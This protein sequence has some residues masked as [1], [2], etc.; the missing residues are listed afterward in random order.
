MN[1]LC[2]I[3]AREYL[4]TVR[5]RAFLLAVVLMPVLIAGSALLPALAERHADADVRRFS[6]VDRTGGE[7]HLG[8]FTA[9]TEREEELR[10][11]TSS[12]ARFEVVP[13]PAEALLRAPEELRA[14]LAE[15]LDSGELFAFVEIEGA[16][17]DPAAGASP[18]YFTR[19]PT[20]TKLHAWLHEEVEGTVHRLRIRRA[21]LDV[22]RVATALRPVPLAFGSLAED[23]SSSQPGADSAEPLRDALSPLI[24]AFLLF[25]V[26][27]SAAGPLMQGVLE[28][29]MQRIAEILVSSVP[30]FQLMLAKL[31]AAAAVSYTLLVLY[32]GAGLFV[33]F[34]LG[35]AEFVHWDDV[36]WGLGFQVIALLMYGSLFLAVGSACSDLKSSQSL[37]M[38]AVLLA[39]A[40]MMLFPVVLMDPSG[41]A[42]TA[43][44][45]IPFF[46]PVLMLL[47]VTLDP[48]APVWQAVL[49]ILLSGG[50]ALLCV[51]LAA[52]IFRIGMLSQGA[53]P[54]LRELWRWLRQG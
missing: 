28:E 27:M 46:T 32:A 38:P 25:L 4:A 11:G 24:M 3:I 7:V 37:M 49:G 17:L 21:G 19:T 33:V 42:A 6:V 16:V 2:A 9:A 20:Y 35:G 52:R 47:R 36:L 53:T 15:K 26:V 45:F 5:T 51:A 43:L 18:R 54:S 29:K 10:A 1:K 23:T 12:G 40:P 30:P 39:S 34:Q 31:I 14:D 8:L 50:T 41:G 13:L 44:S 22:E 48:G